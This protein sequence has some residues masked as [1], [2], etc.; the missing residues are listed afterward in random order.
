L[1]RLWP[2]TSSP[3]PTVRAPPLLH[4]AVDGRPAPAGR[5]PSRIKWLRH[6]GRLTTRPSFAKPLIPQQPAWRPSQIKGLR[7]LGAVESA[8]MRQAPDSHRGRLAS[9]P[10]QGLGTTRFRGRNQDD[11]PCEHQQSAPCQIKGLR[12]LGPPGSAEIRQA[13]DSSADRTIS[14]LPNPVRENRD[15]SFLRRHKGLAKLGNLKIAKRPGRRA[16]GSSVEI[17]TPRAS[18]TSARPRGFTSAGSPCRKIPTVSGRCKVRD[19]SAPGLP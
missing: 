19:I 16:L 6:L 9:L 7:K 5:A 13:P 17:S 15:S 4:L 2:S 11:P 1:A 12:H 10:G 3:G 18:A 14:D 8:E